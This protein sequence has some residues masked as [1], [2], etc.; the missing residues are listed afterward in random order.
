MS[1][2]SLDLPWMQETYASSFEARGKLARPERVQDG[3]GEPIA[4][5]IDWPALD[6]YPCG[7]E[8]KGG[9]YRDRRDGTLVATDGRVRFAAGTDVQADDR[10]LLVTRYG[11]DLEE[12]LEFEVVSTPA[13]GPAGVL[14][15][16]RKVEA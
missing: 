12:A 15:D 1:D 2:L 9:E 6:S 14:A 5:A 10:F 11:S 7:F 3:A 16:V 4:A 8:S 13:V